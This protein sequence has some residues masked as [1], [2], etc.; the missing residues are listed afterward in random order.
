MNKNNETETDSQIQRT[1]RW[2][3]E[4]RGVGGVVSQLGKGD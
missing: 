4:R 3:P 2:L 1:N